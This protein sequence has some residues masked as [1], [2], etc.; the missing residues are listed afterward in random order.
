[1]VVRVIAVIPK[2]CRVITG[3]GN[4][5]HDFKEVFIHMNLVILSTL[6]EPFFVILNANQWLDELNELCVLSKGQDRYMLG[7]HLIMW[8]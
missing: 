4:I 8:Y 6:R 1:M 3:Q 5:Y 7:L 2:G